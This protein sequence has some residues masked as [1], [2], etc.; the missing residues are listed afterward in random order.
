MPSWCTPPSTLGSFSPRV[1]GWSACIFPAVYGD[2]VL[3]TCV[4]DGPNSDTSVRQVLEFSP[5]VWGWSESPTLIRR[6]LSVLPTCVGMVRL[7]A[8]HHW[9]LPCS[10]HVR[11]DGPI[12]KSLCEAMRTSPHV[13]GDG[14]VRCL[15]ARGLRFRLHRKDLP[16]CPD[17]V[18]PRFHAIIFVHG[19]F[20]HGP[21]MPDV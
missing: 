13:S 7:R 4:G 16:G 11:G 15:H 18:F 1:W 14:P 20:W 10:P 9:T 5:R 6:R 12:I 2:L 17:L 21:F 19:C 3:P 8:Y